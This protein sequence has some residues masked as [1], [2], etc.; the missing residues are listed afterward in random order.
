MREH[1]S[2]VGAV[3]A[4]T[5]YGTSQGK[6]QKLKFKD[7]KIDYIDASKTEE[8]RLADSFKQYMK[9]NQDKF[10]VVKNG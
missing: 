2:N 4:Q 9:E 8:E 5:I 6:K 3:I 1:I 10:K 7:F